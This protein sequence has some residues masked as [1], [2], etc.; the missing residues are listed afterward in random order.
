MADDKC[1]RALRV[2]TEE[3]SREGS[4]VIRVEG[5]GGLRVG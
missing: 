2:V 5:G 1:T 3:R 4:K